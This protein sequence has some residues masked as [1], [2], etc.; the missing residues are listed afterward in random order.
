MVA[1]AYRRWSFTGP[2]N[3]KALTGKILVFWS[4]TEVVAHEGSTVYNFVRVCANYKQGNEIEG[5]VQ[6]R[7]CILGV[8]VS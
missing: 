3:S 8:F 4:L 5:V 6:N 1:V 7:V 2:F